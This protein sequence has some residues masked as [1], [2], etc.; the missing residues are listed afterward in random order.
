MIILAASSGLAMRDLLEGL[1]I[2][3][4]GCGA[5]LLSEPLSRIG[6]TVLGIDTTQVSITLARDHAHGD[7]SLDGRLT[8]ECA[9]IDDI[10]Q[11][12]CD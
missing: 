10:S 8:Y 4:V 2:L 5:G 12:V 11:K 3:D 6:A 1:R 9:S 7:N